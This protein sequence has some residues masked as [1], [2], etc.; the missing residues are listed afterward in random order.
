[1]K[2]QYIL[3][4]GVPVLSPALTSGQE[5]RRPNF[6]ICVADDATFE[7]WG[8]M[9]CSWVDTPAFDSIASEGVLY[10]SCYT[11]NAKSAP[12]R[13]CLLTG[14]YSWQLGEAANHICDFPEDQKVFTETL[15]EHGYA[16][17]YTCK[18]W[19]PG[20]P[21][22]KDGKPRQLTGEPYNERV[23]AHRLTNGINKIDYAA[24]FEDFIADHADSSW[25]FWFGC[26]EPHRK[27]EYGSGAA[28]G[29]KS[30]D[31]I[32]E[33]PPFW[34]DCVEVRNDM[35]DYGFEIEYLDSHLGR[36]VSRLDSLGMLD[37]TVVI[38]TSDNGMPFPR[39]KSSNYEYSHHMPL[40]IMWKGGI[41]HPGRVEDSF[42][43]FVDMAPTI[44]DLAG[45]RPDF[46]ME[47]KSFRANLTGRRASTGRKTL[48]FGRERDDNGRPGNQGYPIRG[49]RHGDWLYLHNLK[50]YLMPGGDPLT[51]YRDVD[52]SPTKTAVLDRMRDEA[53]SSWWKLSLGFRPEHELYNVARDRYCMDNLAGDPRHAGTVRRLRKRM[54][55]QLRRQGDPRMGNDG[56]IFDRYPLADGYDP[57]VWE[58]VNDGRLPRP[59]EASNWV[60]PSDYV[61][62]R[63][64]SKETLKNIE[65]K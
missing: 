55:R 16:V 12:S 36:M 22:M 25:F 41:R 5:V 61:Q 3:L 26:K 2:F 13:A 27:Y 15:A 14:K 47:G 18:G 24:N 60:I 59:W 11:P 53:D 35:L 33:V 45:I 28:K 51:G 62:Y 54:E 6:L 63:S 21:G 8:A 52:S 10:T 34:P 58:K 17:G 23:V 56:D 7:H 31:M 20:N 46:N 42:V 65:S 49:I 30:I 64:A 39:G 37:N 32:E 44:L 50:P 43:S 4:A 19:G 38:V 29:D 48:L 57:D 40:A 1:M 9:G